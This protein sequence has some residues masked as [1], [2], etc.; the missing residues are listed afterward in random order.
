MTRSL[1]SAAKR[2]RA[3]RPSGGSS[4]STIAVSSGC[5]SRTPPRAPA[6]TVHGLRRLDD[7]ELG[8][9]VGNGH[10]PD[11]MTTA[12]A[13]RSYPRRLDKVRLDADTLRVIP[14]VASVAGCEAR[15]GGPQRLKGRLEGLPLP[16][17]RLAELPTRVRHDYRELARGYRTPAQLLEERGLQIQATTAR[18]MRVDHANREPELVLHDGDRLLQVRVVRNHDRDLAVA[19]ECVDQQVARQIDVRP[20][21]LG[22]P[23]LGS[24]WSSLGWMNERHPDRPGAEAAEVQQAL[25]DGSDM[26]RIAA[27]RATSSSPSCATLLSS[28]RRPGPRDRIGDRPVAGEDARS[29]RRLASEFFALHH[30]GRD[31]S[32]SL[33]KLRCP[34]FGL[35]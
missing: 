16:G 23:D 11:G 5:S 14:P 13:S 7:A 25:R 26:T 1:A 17:A 35:P 32:R 12:G 19:P 18:R 8:C 2:M 20:L 28:P 27:L 10:R 15:F 22:L 29:R 21:F 4:T 9:G 6:G 34:T 30:S 31:E 3:A 33:R 24:S